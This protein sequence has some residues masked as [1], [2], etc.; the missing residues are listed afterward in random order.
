MSR[1]RPGRVTAAYGHGSGT[2]HTAFTD[3][4]LGRAARRASE[5]NLRRMAAKQSHP[6]RTPGKSSTNK[7]GAT[8]HAQP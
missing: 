1:T 6:D 2:P 8:N 4:A 5:K 7:P 3:I